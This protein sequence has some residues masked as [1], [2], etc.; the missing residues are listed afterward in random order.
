MAQFS[1][2]VKGWNWEE[3]VK[4]EW[5]NGG[6]YNDSGV[7]NTYEGVGQMWKDIVVRQERVLQR[8]FDGIFGLKS[9]TENAGVRIS[10]DGGLRE[11]MELWVLL[12]GFLAVV[13]RVL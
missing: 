1:L 9:D 11:I 7:M 5:Y 4:I 10:D 12:L 3:I 8:G 2:A 13:L 6:I